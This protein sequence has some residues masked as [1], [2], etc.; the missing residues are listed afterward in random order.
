LA[1]KKPRLKTALIE[2]IISRFKWSKQK[3]L[4]GGPAFF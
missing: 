3:W 2:V 1:E 4:F